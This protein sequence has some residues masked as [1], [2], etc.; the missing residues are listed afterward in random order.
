MR[1]G[2]PTLAGGHSPRRTSCDSQLCLRRRSPAVQGA[3]S[4]CLATWPNQSKGQVGPGHLPSPGSLPP[5]CAAVM[6]DS[7]LCCARWPDVAGAAWGTEVRSRG[8]EAGGSGPFAGAPQSFLPFPHY[9]LIAYSPPVIKVKNMKVRDFGKYGKAFERHLSP[10]SGDQQ[11]WHLGT[12]SAHR[13][14]T[15]LPRPGTLAFP[16]IARGRPKAA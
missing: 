8:G 9:S 3:E 4:T 5:S 12:P 10:P 6:A 13:P 16:Q 14:G 15:C 11:P 2:V 1:W 7:R